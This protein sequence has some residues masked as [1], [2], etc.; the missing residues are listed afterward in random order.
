MVSVAIFL[1]SAAV[2]V[3]A[4]ASVLKERRASLLHRT[5]VEITASAEAVAALVND[6]GRDIRNDL[7]L[8]CE[9]RQH[10]AVSRE[11]KLQIV[12]SH[13][14]ALNRS[15]KHYLK[16]WYFEDGEVATEVSG[17]RAPALP[18]P[19]IPAAEI[20]EVDRLARAT[21]GS[22]VSMQALVPIDSPYDSLR[23]LGLSTHEADATV[24]VLVNMDAV[25]DA[26][27]SRASLPGLDLWV[28]DGDG[29]VLV[30]P[31]STRGVEVRALLRG[32]KTGT[33]L[34][35]PNPSIWPFSERGA[36]SQMVAWRAVSGQVFPWV[37][38]VAAPLDGVTTSLHELAVKLLF[39]SS[40]A[41]MLFATA[42]GLVFWLASRQLQLRER[43]RTLSTIDLLRE[44]LLHL[45]KLSTLGQ[46]AAGLAHEMGTPLGVI[47]IR[48]EQLLEQLSDEKQRSALLVMKAQI[49]RIDRIM[50]QVLQ[51]ARPAA[52]EATLVS[53][54]QVAMQVAELMSHRCASREVDLLV[55]VPEGVVVWANADQMQ[56]VLL[57]L[58]VNAC[59]ACRPGD[60]IA[61]RACAEAD[62]EGRSGVAIADTGPGIPA[63][64]LP[65]V[66]EPFFTTKP[67]GQGT[68]LGL[69]IVHEIMER[70]GGRV[71]IDSDANGTRVVT[72]WR[73]SAPEGAALGVGAS[74][75]ASVG[76][77]AAAKEMA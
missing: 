43:L 52:A 10:G 20:D 35:G 70:H 19:Q 2:A 1:V 24:V 54:R 26:L 17:F 64:V 5:E 71:D 39:V 65:L 9:V 32:V 56:Q 58:L 40:I 6:R 45:E 47:A 22:I 31:E 13:L 37:T 12:R 72:W 23:L 60:R 3:G 29:S 75:G 77:G 55:D 15:A 41:L 16:L 76:L 59:D 34:L 62:A 68:G 49:E 66:F 18:V 57:N 38:A 67:P 74:I 4:A 53:V 14:I 48:I 61:V 50:R 27:Q 63:A 30:D 33:A 28:L 7:T 69:T 51:S 73:R 42:G 8:A 21:P 36:D 46:V 44:Q 11:L 25:F